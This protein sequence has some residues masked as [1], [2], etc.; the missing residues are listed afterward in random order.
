MAGPTIRLG[1]AGLGR[2]FALM[3]PTLSRHAGVHLVAAADPRGEARERFAAEFG[4]RTYATV[5]QLCADPGLDAV[6]VAS[7][8]GLHLEH[9]TA[10]ARHGRHVLVEKPM[11]LAVADCRAMIAACADAGVWMV[12][13][14]SH[15]FDAPY[16]RA[17]AL[18]ESGVFGR[19]RMITA[20]NYTD[21]LY[22]PR[23]PEELDTAR[24]GGVVFSQAVHQVDVVRLL[25]GSR[26]CRV[27]AM[28]GNWDAARATEGAY[29]A[30]LGFED[31]AFASLSY[32][33]YAHFDSDEL[34][35]W[36]GEL[37]QAR[38]PASYGEARGRL[39]GVGSAE[40]EAALKAGR[41]YG[42]GAA[43]GAAAGGAAGGAAHNHFGFVVVSCE[44]GDLRPTPGGV[45]VY[46]HERRYF[47]PLPAPAVPRAE[48]VDELHAA[49]FGGVAPLHSGA[50]GL[51]TLETCLAMLRSA[52]TGTEQ[53]LLAG[54][55]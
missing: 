7:P 49:I 6:Y 11:A 19:V 24:G 35:G 26:V 50:W 18:V 21:F 54:G 39:R 2:G 52:E 42:A 37:G 55:G 5:E 10:A 45:Q 13:G 53:E 46:G 30:L 44:G 12:V 28:T 15:S 8:H 47:D 34:Q 51:A 16:G 17:R 40:A 27:R 14:H 32:S 23:R 22:R 29:S 41:A 43:G 31:G 3:L 20:L 25:A 4:A 36:V 48:V 33:G 9:V 38:D 1:V